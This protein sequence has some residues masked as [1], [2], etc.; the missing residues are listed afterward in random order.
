[1]HAATRWARASHR[2]CASGEA[3]LPAA[4]APSPRRDDGRALRGRSAS[5][6]CLFGTRT[7]SRGPSPDEGGNQRSSEAIRAGP[8]VRARGPEGRHLRRCAIGAHQPQSAAIN[9][10]QSAAINPPQSAA[11]NQPQ[12]AAIN[13]PQSAA[14]NPPQ[15]AAINQPQSAAINPPQSATINRKVDGVVLTSPLSLAMTPPSTGGATSR[16]MVSEFEI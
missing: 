5:C 6:D 12:S 15:S 4:G 9:P 8:L 1:M 10:P 13:Q 14:I 7:R 11:I 2:E 3:G 16:P